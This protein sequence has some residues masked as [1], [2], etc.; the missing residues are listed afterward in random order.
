MTN[1]F[2]ATPKHIG[3]SSA[4]IS[5][6]SLLAIVGPRETLTN[7]C[8]AREHMSEWREL[9][10]DMCALIPELSGIEIAVIRS[11]HP[12][13]PHSGTTVAADW[14]HMEDITP[15]L[16]RIYDAIPPLNRMRARALITK[17]VG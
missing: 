13:R 4:L 8:Q 6:S 12:G 3:V 16:V 2:I 7:M 5:L 9:A 14:M 11:A 10:A 15:Y 17:A 1:K